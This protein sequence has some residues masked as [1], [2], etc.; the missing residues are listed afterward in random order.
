[1]TP[2]VYQRTAARR[3]LIDQFVYLAETA[4]LD[5]AEG[6]LSAARTTSENLAEDPK[7]G[8]VLSSRNPKLAGMR[9]WRVTGFEN[10]LSM[11]SR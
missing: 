10:H 11:L 8:A 5:T 1:V 6:F 9:K 3:D 7:L 4:G 2:K